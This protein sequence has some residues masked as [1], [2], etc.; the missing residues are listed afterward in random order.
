[1]S[2]DNPARL[3]RCRDMSAGTS[4]E[5]DS[6]VIKAYH[7]SRSS[8]FLKMLLYNEVVPKDKGLGLWAAHDGTFSGNSSR[9]FRTC[10]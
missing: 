3:C 5:S 10:K 2:S 9:P 4:K 1:V 8:K 6:T 7:T